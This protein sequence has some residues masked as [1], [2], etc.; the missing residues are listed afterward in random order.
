[1][2]H[3]IGL[4]VLGLLLSHGGA[5]GG[6]H[7][8]PILRMDPGLPLGHAVHGLLRVQPQD[9]LPPGGH[10]EPSLQDVPVPQPLVA[11]LHGQG[12]A[13]LADPEGLLPAV[14]G[15][16]HD[17]EGPLHLGDLSKPF[18]GGLQV[19]R[20]LP[21]RQGLGKA[22]Q[23][24]QGTP[25]PAQDAPG[26]PDR[27]GQPPQEEELQDP[28][29]PPGGGHQIR[30]GSADRG[31]P[32]HPGH[33]RRSATVQDPVLLPVEGSSQAE[34]PPI[35]PFHRSP[36]GALGGPGA[37][38]HPSLPV[39]EDQVHPPLPGD[40]FQP[41]PQ[42]LKGHEPHHHSPRPG[43]TQGHHQ[44]PRL[45]IHLGGGPVGG[46]GVG[47]EE[48]LPGVVDP[49]QVPVLRAGKDDPAPGV[50]QEDPVEV[51][52]RLHLFPQPPLQIR[53]GAVPLGEGLGQEGQEALWAL[54]VHP[55]LLGDAP[56][57]DHHLPIPESPQVGTEHPSSPEGHPRQGQEDHQE[58]GS[59]QHPL[60]TPALHGC[61]SRKPPSRSSKTRVAR[62]PSPKRST[63][64]GPSR[65]R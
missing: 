48:G 13:F 56:G 59:R 45:R 53:R 64:K 12:I 61:T 40:A 62:S 7:L 60:Q 11:P 16:D 42:P 15:L 44:V 36:E 26:H 22:L 43:H 37:E 34:G 23:A 9:L 3:P 29:H 20:D 6:H 4:V 41:F 65:P 28:L 33:L 2:V 58:E 25:H 24:A 8:V 18:L 32:P 51:A 19:L 30:H 52:R 1:M 17:V 27:Q 5:Q 10:V 47:Q 63:E 49:H 31:P 50:Q 57:Q 39:L 46:A 21:L 38:D 35:A 14:D 55:R 54:E